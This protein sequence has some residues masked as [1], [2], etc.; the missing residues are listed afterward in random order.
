MI[1]DITKK[2][3]KTLETLFLPAQKS[4]LQTTAQLHENN[5]M[6]QLLLQ[7]KQYYTLNNI[8]LHMECIDISHHG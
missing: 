3:I 1:T 6:G 4:Y 8:P 5:I 2:E 7:I